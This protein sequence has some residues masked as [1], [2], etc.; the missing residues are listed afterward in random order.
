MIRTICVTISIMSATRESGK[1]STHV[2][3][4]FYIFSC[5]NIPEHIDRGIGF[6][7][8]AGLHALIVDKPK[9]FSWTCRLGCGISRV[10]TGDGVDGRFVVEAVEIASGFLE[11]PDP[12][13]RLMGLS[14]H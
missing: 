7:G 3:P 5:Q 1:L 4:F 8:N 11:I 2:R 9:Q 14:A 10:G 12:F 6:N 13:M